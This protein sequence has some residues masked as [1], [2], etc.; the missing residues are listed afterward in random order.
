[1]IFMLLFL[2]LSFNQHSLLYE[3]LSH[4]PLHPSSILEYNKINT[5]MSTHELEFAVLKAHF[6]TH[7]ATKPEEVCAGC[8]RV[9]E[10]GPLRKCIVSGVRKSCDNCHFRGIKC[11]AV[12][13]LYATPRESLDTN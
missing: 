1:M 12:C 5:I 10:Y 7:Y 3:L 2:H 13:S 9:A 8:L 4:L 6:D 11:C